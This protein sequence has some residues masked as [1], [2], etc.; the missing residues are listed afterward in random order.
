[1]K[2]EKWEKAGVCGVDAGLIVIGDPCYYLAD[3]CTERPAKT[4]LEFCGSITT[5]GDTKQLDFKAGHK[6][7]AVIVSNFGGDG[8]YPVSI[9]KDN[10]GRVI[11]ARI[12]FA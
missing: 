11:A 8:C 10:A 5:M 3:D 12:D 7:L 4:W 1:M 9:L 2:N 6:G